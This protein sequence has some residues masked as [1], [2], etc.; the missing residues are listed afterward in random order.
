VGDQIAQHVVGVPA[1]PLRAFVHRYTG[2][3]YEGFDP[4][5]HAG[6]PSRHLTFIVSLDAH[7]EVGDLRDRTAPHRR[8]GALVGGLHTAPAA[9]HHDGN[10]HGIQLEITPQ[11]ARAL[12]G[13]PAAEIVARTVPMDTVLGRLTAQ[14]VDRLHTTATWSRRFELID[15]LLTAAIA[16][17]GAAPPQVAFA[18][19][20]LTATGGAVEVGDLAVEVG[21]S[22]RHMSER[23]RRE[24]GLPPKTMARVIR[25]ERARRMLTEQ[26][27]PSLGAVALAAGYA[28][29][30]HMNRDWREFAGASPTRWMAD[31]RLPFVQD[32]VEVQA[33]DCGH[34]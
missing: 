19:Q 26:R 21:W 22:R 10:Q 16:E 20:R 5:I 7:I 4:G 29:Q 6:L 33:A 28:D 23:F 17:S 25:F 12:F 11:G 15:R 1:P 24:Y 8:F 34:G 14:L 31:E 13:M 27:R 9:I 32:D 18:W 3:R 2:Y 30:A